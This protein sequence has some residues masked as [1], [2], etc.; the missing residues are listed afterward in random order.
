M[1]QRVVIFLLDAATE[2]EAAESWYFERD[3]EVARRFRS[4]LAVAVD[5]ITDAP[6]RWPSTSAGA[7]RVLLEGFPYAVHYRVDERAIVIAAVA[8]QRRRP[9]YW[10]QR[11]SGRK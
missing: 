1:S 7:H 9:G 2:A 3:A 5:K 11:G 6:E 4:A 10:Q 8:H